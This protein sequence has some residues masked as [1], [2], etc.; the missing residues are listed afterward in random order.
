MFGQGNGNPQWRNKGFFSY[1]EKGEAARSEML[2]QA[3][4]Q[5]WKAQNPAMTNEEGRELDE[6]TFKFA[7]LQKITK[8]LKPSEQKWILDTQKHTQKKSS[9]RKDQH[10]IKVSCR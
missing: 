2:V 3:D 8:V 9:W 6:T 5:G 10:R 1:E 4:H 7:V